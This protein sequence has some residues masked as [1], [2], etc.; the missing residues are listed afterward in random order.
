LAPH[1]A[2]SR[3]TARAW[4]SAREAEESAAIGDREGALR[5]MERAQAVYDYADPAAEQ[6]WVRSFSR[7]RLDSM[8]VTAYARRDHPDLAEVFDAA[9]HAL[10]PKDAKVQAVILGDVAKA[11]VQRGDLDRGTAV[12]REAPTSPYAPRRRSAGSG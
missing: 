6:P 10:R 12:A 5:A 3:A 8:T 7:S 11:Y 2:L 4:V 9:L 1:E